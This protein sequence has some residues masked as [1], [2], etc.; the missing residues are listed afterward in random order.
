MER[1]TASLRCWFGSGC[2]RV[3]VIDERKPTHG[4]LAPLWSSQHDR[5]FLPVCG[6]RSVIE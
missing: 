4:C 3:S 1:M 6:K 2:F 5:I